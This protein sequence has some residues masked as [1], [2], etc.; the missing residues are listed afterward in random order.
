MSGF[1][2][3]HTKTASVATPETGSPSMSRDEIAFHVAR[4]ERLRAAA[5]ARWGRRWGQT[6]ASLWHRPGRL[7]P[8]TIA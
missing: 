3:E 7:V 5:I 4:G 2:H 1:Q 6:V 8:K